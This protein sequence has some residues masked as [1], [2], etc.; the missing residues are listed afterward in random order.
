MKTAGILPAV[1]QDTIRQ[2]SVAISQNYTHI[3]ESSQTNGNSG[4]PS[5]I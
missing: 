1:V 3:D 2:E 4:F 5:L